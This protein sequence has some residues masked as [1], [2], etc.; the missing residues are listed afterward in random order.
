MIV[1]KKLRNDVDVV[2]KQLVKDINP[3]DVTKKC[4][5]TLKFSSG[6]NILV[7]IGKAAWS[8]ASAVSDLIPIDDGVVITKYKYSNGPINNL[9]IFEAGHPIVDENSI[10]ATKSALEL[11][12]NL[13][14]EDNVILCISGGGSALFEK[15]LIGLQDLQNINDLLIKS[16]ADINEINIIRKRLSSVKAGRFALHCLPAHINAIILSDVVG[17]DLSTIASGPV[18]V[19]SYTLDDAIRIIDKYSININSEVRELLNKETPKKIDNV[20]TYVVGSVEQ[21]CEFAKNEFEKL[22]Y[23]TETIQNNSKDNVVDIAL[24]FKELINQKKHNHAYIIGGESVVEVKGNGLGGRNTEL[25]LLCAEHIKDKDNMCVFTFGSDGTDGPT[26]AAGGYV[27][28]NTYNQIDVQKYLDNNDSYH[29]L[30]KTDGLI[31]TG[32]TGSNVNDIYVLLVK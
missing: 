12:D 32:P 17:N 9:K 29:A 16:G 15:P 6:R 20:E 10:L 2:V 4:V 22:G 24:K 21:L 8:M 31:K 11:T 26:D 23:E 30:E 3:Y 1:N 27:D 7:S 5:K 13:T 14:S 25:A 19:D 18:S 28:G